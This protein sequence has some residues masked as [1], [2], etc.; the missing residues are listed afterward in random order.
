MLSVCLVVL[1]QSDE[2]A[3]ER[4]EE[5]DHSLPHSASPQTGQQQCEVFHQE[6]VT[7]SDAASTATAEATVGSELPFDQGLLITTI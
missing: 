4:H 7:H 2:A 6:T 1:C 5:D 3:S